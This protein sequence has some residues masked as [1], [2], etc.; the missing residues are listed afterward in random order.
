MRACV[1]RA[2]GGLEQVEIAEVPAPKG[3]MSLG[4]REV[5]VNVRAAALNH[6][7]LFVIEGLPVDYVFPHVLGSDGAGVVDAAGPEVTAVRPGDAVMINPGVACHACE[8]CRAGEHSLCVDYRVLGE[9][10]PGTMAEY[11]VVPEQNVAR[12]PRLVPELTWAE[13]AAF[14]LVTLTAW[15]MVVSR[16]QVRT[17][18]WVLVWGI[19]G[20]VALTALRI[21]KLL[22]AR[23]IA[24]SS[25]EAKLEQARSFGADAILNHRAQQVAREVRAL[26]DRH[27]ADV[28]VDTTGAATWQES[29]KCLARG[30]RVVTCGATTGPTVSMDV[31]RLFWHQHTILGSTMGN[32]AEYQQALQALG[33]GQLRPLVDR[34]YSLAEAR[35]ALERLA[36][37]SQMG[38]VVVG[39]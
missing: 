1:I 30:G 5:R 27:G 34:V 13:A 32:E 14:S 3:G 39:I 26:T 22:G 16:A 10:L 6:L 21:A 15:R 38:K 35:A 18:E 12:I 9:H 19:G 8:F 2:V 28:V 25:S 11:V 20:G 23:V 17:G 29:L 36:S 31:R 33:D 4:A 24:T 7:D 37:G